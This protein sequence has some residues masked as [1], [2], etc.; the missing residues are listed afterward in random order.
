MSEMKELIGIFPTPVLVKNL[1]R[2]LSKE[3][4]EYFHRQDFDLVKNQGNSTTSKRDILEENCLSSIKEFCLNGIN[5]YISRVYD[6]VENIEPYITQSWLNYTINRQYH[7][8]HNHP[9]SFLSGVFY[10]ETDENDKIELLD[11]YKYDLIKFTPKNDNWYNEI[12][13]VIPAKQYNLV[14]FPSKIQHQVP[15]RQ[16]NS[17]R[18]SLAFNTFLRGK[19]GSTEDLTELI[20]K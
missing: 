5:E 8:T 11:Y 10:I 16:S 2:E 18:L 7:H 9:N 3:E 15:P 1:N 20:L 17:I 6:P 4:S 19:L 12:K 14:I 13:H